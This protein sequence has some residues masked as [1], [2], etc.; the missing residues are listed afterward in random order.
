VNSAT[1]RRPTEFAQAHRTPPASCT[2]S[3][4]SWRRGPVTARRCGA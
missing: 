4:M 1:Q 2:M 3:S